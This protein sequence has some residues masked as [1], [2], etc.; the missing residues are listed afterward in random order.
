MF[1][2]PFTSLAFLANVVSIAECDEDESTPWHRCNHVD[3]QNGLYAL[4]VSENSQLTS[5]SLNRLRRIGGPLNLGFIAEREAVGRTP[6]VSPIYIKDNEQ[7]CLVDTIDWSELSAAPFPVGAT[8]GKCRSKNSFST[9]CNLGF[10]V[11]FLGSARATLNVESYPQ[12]CDQLVLDKF[13]TEPVHP[14]I[15]STQE[16]QCSA[17]CGRRGCWDFTTAGCQLCPNA[18]D[19]VRAGECISGGCEASNRLLSFWRGLTSA[20]F[21]SVQ[22]V[23]GSACASTIY[24]S[25]FCS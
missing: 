25:V 6:P 14:I 11:E 3:L 13:C 10:T 7:L 16:K 8:D 1:Q 20:V 21:C 4:K 24:T 17:L 18:A 12:S 15:C 23:M 19:V 9:P 5:L 22:D 2:T